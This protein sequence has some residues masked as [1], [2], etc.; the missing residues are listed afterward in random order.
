MAS[1]LFMIT[2]VLQLLSLVSFLMLIFATV[3]FIHHQTDNAFMPFWSYFRSF[4]IAFP[5]MVILIAAFGLAFLAGKEL[6]EIPGSII[7]FLRNEFSQS[8]MMMLTFSVLSLAGSV[9]ALCHTE[10]TPPPAY[11]RL[12][13]AILAGEI[14][15][16]EE[17]IKMIKSVSEKNPKFAD[18][19]SLVQR[20]FELRRQRNLEAK[21]IDLVSSRLLLR[22]LKN[23]SDETWTSHPLRKHALAEA[24][25]L[26][27]EAVSGSGSLGEGFGELDPSKLFGEAIK[28]YS[29]VRDTSSARLGT[30]QLIASAQNN[31]G[32][33]YYYQGKFQIA[34]DEWEKTFRNHPEHKN[35]GTLANMV[36]A[37]IVLGKHDVAIRL[38]KESR[39]WAEENGKAIRDTAH[40]A[41]LLVNTGFAYVAKGETEASQPLFEFAALVENDDN[42]RLNVVLSYAIVGRSKE[43][44]K[45]LRKISSPITHKDI[46]DDESL[47]ADKR[48]SYLWWALYSDQIDSRDVAARLF[49]FLG[50]KHSEREMQKYTDPKLLLSLRTRIANELGKFPGSCN[51]YALIKPIVDFVRGR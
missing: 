32:N 51:T 42:S 3:R 24:H 46:T 12:V 8:H 13:S 18:Q 2:A 5:P 25:L 48:C 34:L 10:S 31:I 11:K 33:A 38:G 14:D 19:L 17:A 15:R 20:V 40:Y 28:L 22:A 7:S 4:Q 39:N 43:A 23:S 44:E 27:A 47:T 26:L 36:A 49:A 37:N 16:S 1:R 45:I 21:T 6:S 9:V 30:K 50:E 41:S 35:V 29:E